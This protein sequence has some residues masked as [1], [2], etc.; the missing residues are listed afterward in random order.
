MNMHG[1]EQ[2]RFDQLLA[3]AADDTLA[4]AQRAELDA[5]LL[6]CDA[7]RA[8]LAEQRDARAILMAR[9][10]LPVR[11][12]SAGIRSLLEAER[13]WIDR[14]NI[15]WRVWS[16]RVAPVA[17][18]LAIVAVMLVRAV[19]TASTSDATVAATTESSSSVASALWNGEASDDT[20]LTVLLHASP[21]EA[22]STSALDASGKG[23]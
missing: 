7:C 18:A 3:Q 4:P 8:R 21:E 2:N 17:A 16:L 12:L 11:D 10:V 14:L 1:H 22:L 23:R 20:L 15:N 9:A 19:D 13:P 5:H 6:T